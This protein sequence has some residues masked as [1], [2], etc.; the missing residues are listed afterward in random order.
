MYANPYLNK[1][2]F[3][4]KHALMTQG[5]VSRESPG[6]LVPHIL[7]LLVPPRF[8]EAG[9]AHGGQ[10]TGELPPRMTLCPPRFGM[11]DLF[12]PTP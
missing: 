5:E 2:G 12:D 8:P 9:V 11:K 3:Y 6:G 1:I 10:I 7:L 4:L